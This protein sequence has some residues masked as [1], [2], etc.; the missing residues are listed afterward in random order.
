MKPKAKTKKTR[1]LSHARSQKKLIERLNTPFSNCRRGIFY[2]AK[3][4]RRPAKIGARMARKIYLAESKQFAKWRAR[5][6][7]KVFASLDYLGCGILDMMDWP[8]QFISGWQQRSFTIWL[9]KQYIHWDIIIYGRAHYYLYLI[10]PYFERWQKQIG[11]FG[12]KEQRIFVKALAEIGTE[13]VYVTD[14]GIWYGEEL[15]KIFSKRQLRRRWNYFLRDCGKISLKLIERFGQWEQWQ[16]EVKFSPR[17]LKLSASGWRKVKQVWLSVERY[18]INYPIPKPYRVALQKI[19]SLI[20]VLMVLSMLAYGWDIP[21]TEA[22]GCSTAA[23][24]TGTDPSTTTIAPGSG[25]ADAGIF[26]ITGS[27][28]SCTTKVTAVTVTLAASGTPY[29][30]LAE[31]R[32]TSNDNLT[33]YFTT[34]TTFA[35]NSVSFSGGTTSIPVGIATAGAVPFKIRITPLSATGMPA[36]PGATYALSPYISAWTTTLTKSGSDSNANTITIDNLSPGNVTNASVTPGTESAA[37]SWTNPGDADVTTG[38]SIVVL[39][40]T[41]AITDTPVEGTIYSVGNTISP[42]NSYVACVV[43]GSP[44]A[45]SCTDTGLTA[46]TPYYYKIFAEDSNENF[47]QTGVIPT[48][49]PGTPTGTTTLSTATD[50]NAA[51]VAPGSGIV[52]A[53]QFTYTTSSGTDTI[54]AL[55][56]TLGGSPAGSYAALTSVSIR[57]GTCAG[58]LYFAAVTP[59]GDS[60]SFSGGTA[61]PVSTSGNTYLICVTPKDQTLGAGTYSVSPYVSSTW[62]SGSS[63]AKA[64]TDSNANALTIDNTAPNGATSTSGSAGT[65]KV[66]LNWTASNSADISQSVILRWTAAT[67]GA[68]VPADGSSYTAGNTITTAT[69]ACVLT[70]TASQVHSGVIDGTAGSAGCN[71]SALTNG[72]AYS[73]KVFQKDSYGNYDAGVTFNGSPFTPV[74]ATT[75]LG[76]GTNSAAAPTIGPGGAQT[77]IDR[78]SFATDTGTDTVTALTVTLGPLNAYNNVAT[79]EVKTTGGVSKCT[80]STISSNTVSLSACAIAVT[81][82]PTEYVVYVTPKSHANMPA[83]PGASYATTATVTDWTGTNTHA[84]SDAGSDTV[85]IDNASPNGATATS[86]TAGDAK[87]TIN[88]TTS[89]SSDFNATSGSVLLRW[90]AATPGAEVPVEG[91]TYAAGNTISTATVACVISSAASTSLSKVDGTG[92]SAG[93]TTAALTN[94][95]AY[96]YKIFQKDNFGNYDAGTTISGSPFTPA[97][98]PVTTLATGSDPV[99]ATVAPGSGITDGGAFT[100]STNTGT[101][102]VTALTVTLAASGTPYNGLAEVRVTSSDGATLYF[103]AVTSFASNTVNFSGGTPI[104]VT[105]TPTTFKIRITPLSHANMPA[106]PGASYALTAYVSAFTST[107]GQAGTDSNANTLTIDNASP[108]N[109]AASAT[110]DDS[111]VTLDWTNPGDADYTET[112]ILKNTGSITDAPTEGSSPTQGTTIGTSSV[113]YVGTGI[114]LN[115]SGLTNGTA[116]YY[117]FFARDSRGNFSAGVE[118]SATPSLNPTT[119]IA[120]GTDPANATVEPGTSSVVL[121]NFTLRTNT[122]TDSVTALT[123]TTTSTSTITS[124]KI[125]SNDQVTQYFGTVTVP[126]GDNWNFSGGTAIDLTT[127]AV[128]YKILVNF[129]SHASLTLNTFAVTGR[130]ASYTS[131][132]PSGGSDSATATITVDNLPATNVTAATGSAGDSEVSLSW[133]NPADSD[134]SSVI[135]LR[136]TSAVTDSPVAG[137]TYLLGNIIGS[138]FVA[139][140]TASTSCDSLSLSN[141]TA[142]YY[143]IFTEDLRHNYSTGVAPAGSPFTPVLTPTT[144]LA[145]GTDPADSSAL[146]GSGIMDLDAFEFSTNTG[147]D[148]ITDLTL[149]LAAGTHAGIS[150]ISV[151]SD[152]GLTEY[153]SPVSDPSADTIL[154]SGGTSIPVTT[155]ATQYK[156][157]ITPKTHSQMPVPP[158]AVYAINGQITSYTSTNGRSGSDSSSATITIDN[159][160]P[161]NP[162]SAT[163][164]AGDAQ[165]EL[166]WTNPADSDFSNV[167]ILRRTSAI[168]DTPTEGSTPAVDDTVGSSRVIYIS[169]ATS[170]TDTGLTNGTSYYYKIFAKDT[171]GNYSTGISFTGSPAMPISATTPAPTVNSGGG[172]ETTPLPQPTPAPIPVPEEPAPLPPV[173]EPPSK[174][175]PPP[176]VRKPETPKPIATKPVTPNPN[177][178]PPVLPTVS[179]PKQPLVNL[180]V[181]EILDRT[182]EFSVR[183]LDS[184]RRK[185]TDT[186]SG[187]KQFSDSVK[188]GVQSIGQKTEGAGQALIGRGRQTYSEIEIALVVGARSIARTSIQMGSDVKA[189]LIGLN[190]SL[191]AAGK[192]TVERAGEAIDSTTKFGSLLVSATGRKL[193]NAASSLS[194]AVSTAGH[195]VGGRVKTLSTS[196]ARTLRGGFTFIGS[197]LKFA[198]KPAM[199]PQDNR[200]QLSLKSGELEM[201][202]DQSKPIQAVVGFI[203]NAEI[204]TSKP[205]NNVGGTFKFTDRNSDGIWTADVQMP[206]TPGDFKIRTKIDYADGSSKDLLSSVVIDPEGYVYEQLPRGQLRV[207]DAKVTLWQKSGKNWV[208]W[209]A[210]R[211]QQSNPQMTDQTGEYSFLAPAGEYYLEV[212]AH[213][214]GVYKGPAFLLSETSPIHETVRLEYKGTK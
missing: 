54:T 178:V 104:P 20:L 107:N 167:V 37:L 124:M 199:P 25:I 105:T 18:E 31:V 39:R 10:R 57:A 71:T 22:A 163:V 63:N 111:L 85:T 44:P 142:Y 65:G 83:P 143:K 185:F 127:S 203:F 73:Y 160:S 26:T 41:S 113:L 3:K 28:T 59:T 138:A 47:S 190:T 182:K 177:P 6:G 148:T 165:T 24:G 7:K 183:S 4:I 200:D 189:K 171:N 162:T 84:G 13:L 125:V 88:W 150:E 45:T 123:V 116:Y 147:T 51:T 173:M 157:R 210:G 46:G 186:A 90:A 21:I 168:T 23:L 156:I 196:T 213:E 114:T 207:A 15:R 175:P 89:N 91:S 76:N 101:D 78:F 159:L 198:A 137:S 32:I 36:V 12:R 211:Y 86:G 161:A 50:P 67:P 29:N 174:I 149:T 195:R 80:Q 108:A 184:V 52:S 92:G 42:G 34:V 102:S 95:Q 132:N 56:V 145:N 134:F 48:G 155:S 93:C 170:F 115:D 188:T 87:N 187:L 112:I 139:C 117:K 133:T 97:L 68:E 131:T 128:S 27:G 122:G 9:R 33:T 77:E 75:T 206:T 151:T 58:T 72:Q 135:V 40:N 169:N 141:G 152:S 8:A 81:T 209:P 202:A 179:A 79:V 99:T 194:S 212:T 192:K 1:A 64:G 153:F 38:G 66:T 204:K 103:A 110:P 16:W 82:T 180:P 193:N 136:G 140:V 172:G 176:V 60:V 121:D 191:V 119:I 69:V 164:V 5:E 118:V 130:V 158:G 126:S 144:T 2:L 96:S 214:Y 17:I 154:F 98:T 94:A 146:P 120:N 181:K 55:T 61:L 49:S 74:A 129:A 166:S 197:R 201:L 106:P 70:S 62:T 43:T 205:A 19:T 35:S 109:P 100:L 14:V 30:G 11:K 53:G 208:V